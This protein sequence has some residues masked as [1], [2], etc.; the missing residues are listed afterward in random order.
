ML[1]EYE[2]LNELDKD[3][4][5]AGGIVL[6]KGLE[7]R[8]QRGP[9]GRGTKRS[10]PNG[11]FVETVLDATLQRIK[12]YQNNTKFACTEN[13]RAIESII[14]ALTA[15]NSRT[16]RREHEGVEGTHE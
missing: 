5:P 13:E 4:N 10:E 12:F 9:L 15:L 1:D 11:A 16:Q 2:A 3:G 14:T 8:W 7:I 6:G